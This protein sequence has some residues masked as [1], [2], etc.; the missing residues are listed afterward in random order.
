VKLLALLLLLPALAL[1]DARVCGFVV[2]DADNR[3]ARSSTV[4]AEFQ[5][6]HPCPSTGR[7]TGP[8]KG[9]AIDHV[10]PLSCGGCDMIENL[11][12]LKN[13]IKSCAGREC[14]DRW[15]RKVYCWPQ[16]IVK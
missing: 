11:Q 5:K 9:W 13:S 4:L 2:R 12:W 6:I 16:E 15:E 1:A 10:L 3:I 7:T 14:K 8:C